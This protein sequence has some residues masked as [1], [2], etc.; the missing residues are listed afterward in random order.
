MI[1]MP[2]LSPSPRVPSGPQRACD[3]LVLRWYDHLKGYARRLSPS[4]QAARGRPVLHV[5][6]QRSPVV[7]TRPPSVRPL[8]TTGAVLRSV[9]HNLAINLAAREPLPGP[10]V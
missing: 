7:L 6:P 8:P 3:Q 2:A 9:V 5:V 1:L 4:P 10:R